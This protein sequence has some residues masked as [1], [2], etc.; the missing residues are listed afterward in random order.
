M[1]ALVTAPEGQAVSLQ[2]AEQDLRAEVA[3]AALADT[4]Q[5]DTQAAQERRVMYSFNMS[6]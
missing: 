1:E 6:R 2:L 5:T 4:L 3:A